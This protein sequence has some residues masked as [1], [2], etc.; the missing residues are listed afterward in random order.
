V[1]V[2]DAEHAE[3]KG[4]L[5]ALSKPALV[6]DC[7]EELRRAKESHALRRKVGVIF[8]TTHALELCRD[9]IGELVFMCKEVHI[10]N[11]ICKPVQNRQCDALDLAAR[12]D[13]MIVVGSATSANTT[14]LAALCRSHNPWTLQIETVDDLGTPSYVWAERVGIASGLSTPVGV[15]E[16]VRDA[17]VGC[18]ERPDPVLRPPASCYASPRD[19]R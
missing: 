17:I 11:T 6:V 4:I 19:G 10:I 9:M 18:S 8:Q 7:V 5:G 13:L 1:I 16:Q 3:I 2:G 14:Q 15:V 12:V